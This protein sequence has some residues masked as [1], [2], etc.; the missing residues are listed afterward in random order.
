MAQI[1]VRSILSALKNERRKINQAIT[2]LEAVV[3]RR[4]VGDRKILGNRP[5][6]SIPKTKNGTVGQVVPFAHGQGRPEA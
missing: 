3:K 2:A 5:R 6:L 4:E 1:D